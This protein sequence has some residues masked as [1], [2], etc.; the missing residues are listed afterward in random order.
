MNNDDDAQKPREFFIEDSGGPMFDARVFTKPQTA[1]SIHVIGFSSYE[2][3]KAERDEYIDEA[4]HFQSKTIDLDQANGMLKTE[5][6]ALRKDRDELKKLNSA[7]YQ[8]GTWLGMEVQIQSGRE[9]QKM[10]QQQCDDYRYVLEK[11]NNLSIWNNNSLEEDFH[12][13]NALAHEVLNK[14]PKG[15]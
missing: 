14:Y 5:I 2:K 1:N 13:I 3:L 11:I 6:E 15:E 10:I 9:L 4:E 8:A 12:K 7:I